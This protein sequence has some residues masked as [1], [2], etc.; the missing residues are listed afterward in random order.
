MR[1]EGPTNHGGYEPVDPIPSMQPSRDDAFNRKKDEL[2]VSDKINSNEVSKEDVEIIKLEN[3]LRRVSEDLL[4]IS[5]ISQ[6]NPTFA[7]M[8]QGKLKILKDNQ[9]RISGQIQQLK[10]GS[11]SGDADLTIH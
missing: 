1:L 2:E 3:E 7:S 6:M 10:L 5:Q 11:E 9:V 8:N 4:K